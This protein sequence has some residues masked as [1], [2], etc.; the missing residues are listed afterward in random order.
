MISLQN[1]KYMIEISRHQSISSAAKS[2]FISQSTLSTAI[3]EVEQSLGILLFKRNSRGVELTYEGLD[4]INHAKDILEQAEYLERRY[5]HKKSL[6]MRFSVST[7]RLPFATKA[8]IK[9]ID[10]I[11]LNRYD[12]AVRECPTHEVIHDVATRRSEI[13][14]LC[15]N[16]HYL[17]TMQKL[18]DAS[19]LTFYTLE[20]IK[21]YVFVRKEHPLASRASLTIEDLKAYPFVTYDQGDDNLLHFSEEIIFNEILDKN[22]H[23]IDRCTKIALV[24][25][26]DCFSIGPDLTN[27]D[28]DKM[29]SNLSEIRAISFSDNNQILYAGYIMRSEHTLSDMGTRYIKILEEE[30]KGLLKQ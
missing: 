14:V 22:I 7:Q 19:N 21:N 29:H 16:D 17:N 5:Q 25:W 23:V 10:V 24:R 8:F 3:K 9:I 30:I 2:L 28:G 6:P 27:S 1:I 11:G 13:G 4:Y 26:T 15:I 18:L 12:V 20:K